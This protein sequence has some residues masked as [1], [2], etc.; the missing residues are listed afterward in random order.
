MSSRHDEDQLLSVNSN[1]PNP[2]Q[3]NPTSEID[4]I[5]PQHQQF[6]S[7]PNVPSHSEDELTEVPEAAKKLAE[8]ETKK[9]D[10][11][12]TNGIEEEE[13][14]DE[15]TAMNSLEEDTAQEYDSETLSED[16]ACSDTESDNDTDEEVEEDDE[17]VEMRRKLDQ[18]SRAKQRKEQ[19]KVQRKAAEEAA[20]IEAEKAKNER[21][22]RPT[23]TQERLDAERQDEKRRETERLQRERIMNERTIS[24]NGSRSEVNEY[25]DEEN[26]WKD[27][28][29]AQGLVNSEKDQA[30]PNEASQE[31]SQPP[32]ESVRL[33]T[34]G[35]P[36]TPIS[37]Q[38]F[39]STQSEPVFGQVFKYDKATGSKIGKIGLEE[40][41]DLVR[42]HEGKP[43]PAR[44][45][46]PTAHGTNALGKLRAEAQK[47]AERIRAQ[48][49]KPVSQDPALL[50]QIRQQAQQDIGNLKKGILPVNDNDSQVQASTTSGCSTPEYP[51]FVRSVTHTVEGYSP[52][53]TN[54]NIFR[55]PT[56]RNRPKIK[57]KVVIPL[58]KVTQ[59][60]WYLIELVKQ[61][62]SWSQIH[63]IWEAKTGVPRGIDFYKYRYRR[64]QTTFPDHIPPLSSPI[65]LNTKLQ[66][67]P[68]HT[69]KDVMAAIFAATPDPSSSA[70]VSTPRPTTGGK[71]ITPEMAR[72]FLARSPT[73][74]STEESDEEEEDTML[75]VAKPSSSNLKQDKHH[76]HYT[77]QVERKVV[78]GGRNPSDVPW[79]AQSE[80]IRSKKAANVI[81]NGAIY[82]NHD[83]LDF[84]FD[85]TRGR[86]NKVSGLWSA[87]AIGEEG[88]IY[89]RVNRRLRY[90]QEGVLVDKAL[91]FTVYDVLE[92]RTITITTKEWKL[93][94]SPELDHEHADQTLSGKVDD[95]SGDK[96]LETEL[97]EALS[98]DDEE[99]AIPSS[100][101]EAS[102][103]RTPR[104]DNAQVSAN[105][106]SNST[107]NNPVVNVNENDKDLDD[108]FHEDNDDAD[109]K[110]TPAEKK[111]VHFADSDKVRIY[112][113]PDDTTK[114]PEPSTN[115]V[116]A[117]AEAEAGAGAGAEAMADTD[118]ETG[119]HIDLS[120]YTLHTTNTSTSTTSIAANTIYTHLHLA[121]EAALQRLYTLRTSSAS[122]SFLSNPTIDANDFSL[123]W[124]IPG[125]M[126]LDRI[127]HENRVRAEM[128]ER[129]AQLDA[130][131]EETLEGGSGGGEGEFAWSQAVMRDE[132]K[133]T[134]W[135]R[136]ESWDGVNEQDEDEEDET[137]VRIRVTTAT[138]VEIWVQA[139]KIEGPRNP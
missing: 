132:M 29:R 90:S 35:N 73:P 84:K 104:D 45:S 62:L 27:F 52:S 8:E 59:D 58:E 87:E 71:T 95:V 24:S 93:R 139:R 53:L 115:H 43:I 114:S 96:D 6:E 39:W 110:Q 117:E 3:T 1:L 63:E 89:V 67:H 16:E 91:P 80:E 78:L 112:Q 48:Q 82:T 119:I 113:R 138:E 42:R 100:G 107:L 33:D 81:A 83:R 15:D 111:H 36:T 134:A 86:F 30:H 13:T 75:Q 101:D 133:G 22:V 25:D 50:E 56:K 40:A 109:M 97:E 124:K 130:L 5:K 7:N 18:L 68:A 123:N 85:E 54:H 125:R 129:L 51:Q 98:Q 37:A 44:T 92:K 41:A 88:T 76:V 65:T 94:S 66:K 57:E 136:V 108:L 77:Y 49:A 31:T 19:Q 64:M 12:A 32:T 74:E 127:P 105:N 38:R 60:D 135:T 120:N 99:Q 9:D 17:I 28:T 72:Y 70:E 128:D 20:A 26:A 55:K 61:G 47:D 137:A 131:E 121:N 23:L 46:L 118:T 126:S 122:A 69:E 11:A 106:S 102:Q 116:E 103:H 21:V 4:M 14:K 34:D 10:D 79:I 2:P